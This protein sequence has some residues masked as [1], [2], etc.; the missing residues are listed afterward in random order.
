MLYWLLIIKLGRIFIC[1]L[2]NLNMIRLN[3][4][5]NLLIIIRR[6]INRLMGRKLHRNLSIAILALRRRGKNLSR[7]RR[8]LR[9]PCRLI[10]LYL[11]LGKGVLLLWRSRRRL[12]LKM[13][14]FSRMRRI[15]M[16]L[17]L[18]IKIKGTFMLRKV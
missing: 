14:V 4:L 18:V 9:V 3:M 11:R 15:V 2:R 7:I 6:F 5:G 8:L 12:N 10:E 16:L 13:R 1:K 17:R